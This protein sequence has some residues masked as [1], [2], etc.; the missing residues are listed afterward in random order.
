VAAEEDLSRDLLRYAPAAH[1]PGTVPTSLAHL[2]GPSARPDLQANQGGLLVVHA[3]RTGD[4]SVLAAGLLLLEAALPFDF[5]FRGTAFTNTAT[6]YWARY[7]ATGAAVDLDRAVELGTYTVSAFPADPNHALAQSNL[8]TAYWARYELASRPDDLAS[9]IH[10]LGQA[11][12]LAAQEDPNRLVT[13]SNLGVALH[14]RFEQTG[15]LADLDRAIDLGHTTT[16]A[17]TAAATTEHDA[18]RL[19]NLGIAHRTRYDRTGDTADLDSAIEYGL[20]ALGAGPAPVHLPVVLTNLGIAHHDRFTRHGDPADL[21]RAIDYQERSFAALPAD[22]HDRAPHLNNTASVYLERFDRTG[23]L[24][25]LDRAIATGD[26][27]VAAI[28]DRHPQLAWFLSTLGAALQR[29]FE[30]T[31]DLADLDRAIATK[32]HAVAISPPTAPGRALHLS[33]LGVARKLRFERTGDLADLNRAV[34]VS[35]QALAATPADHADL[36]MRHDN[37]A[38]AYAPRFDRTGVGDDLDR[39]ITH[40]EQAAAATPADHPLLARTLSNLGTDYK[41]RHDHAG[42]RADLDRAIAVGTRAVAATPADHPDLPVRLSN[43]GVAYH[44]R[45]QRVGDTADLDR[46]V[47]HLE[48]ALALTPAD[49]PGRSRYASNLVTVY[50]TRYSRTGDGTDLD[51]AVE[52][53]R[54]SVATTPEGHPGLG[55]RLGNL[56]G[57]LLAR[58]RHS[59]DHA[60]LDEAIVHEEHALAATAEDHP[61]Y[62][63]RVGALGAG[64]WSRAASTGSAQDWARAEALV[65]RSVAATA[66]DHPYRAM[67][68]RNLLLLLEER[69]DV[70]PMEARLLA[71]HVLA[72]R[73]SP[74]AQQVFAHWV[75][76]RVVHKAGEHELAGRL[77]DSAVELLPS[78]PARETSHADQE[79]RLDGYL[80]L[81]G[82]AV[83]VHCALGDPVGAVR[84]AEQG[85]G[86]LLAAQLDART[87]L[88]GLAAEHPDL[89]ARFDRVR[90]ALDVPDGGTE[91]RRRLWTEHDDLLTHIRGLPGW[92]RFL[93]PPA[94]ADLRPAAEGGSVV[95]VNAGST[96]ADAVIVTADADPV[97][98]PLPDLTL[99]DVDTHAIALAAAT[100]ATGFSAE[101]RRQRVLTDLLAWLWDTTVGPVLD[102]V[103]GGRVWWLPTGLLGQLP[104]HAAGHPGQPGAL[105]RVVSSYTPT[106]RALLRSRAQPPAEGSRLTVAMAHTPGLPDLPATVAEADNLRADTLLRDNHA[107]VADVLRALPGVSVAHF[108]CHA[109]TNPDAPSLGGLHLHDGTLPITAVSRLRL[110][111][112]EL[113]YLSA[114]STGHVSRGHANESTHLASAF[115]LAGFRHVIASLWPLNDE[116]A[117]TAAA[118]FHRHTTPPATTLHEVTR[119]LRADHPDRPHLWAPLIHSG[120]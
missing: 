13:A 41:A 71:T 9:A 60:D 116:V 77:L 33:N 57:I 69:G 110:R 114:C 100:T 2:L 95:L 50:R 97:L 63:L 47:T 76:G 105:D 17:A 99:T 81:V 104:L 59:G 45:H 38:G 91:A 53:G 120:P 39:A 46:A 16:T 11:L 65:R 18:A 40:R 101:L 54:Q 78:V 80:G 10:F 7:S 83:A 48:R 93:L 20:L 52:V 37:L 112:A 29:R 87:D 72:A 73:R 106:L 1:V 4:Q 108:A 28:P 98:V 34:D 89:A 79:H 113:A 74:P 82:E 15:D 26:G 3:L 62:A 55:I 111:G 94:W 8:G 56:G 92:D 118:R 42:D 115:Q 5:P 43:V 88:S 27:A 58:F 61:A 85:R 44:A 21:D 32:E 68:L 51:R 70:P 31:G 117:A 30:R 36:A 67:R 49:H 90:T 19:S 75:A 6:A 107:T 24:S 103:E 25:D 109:A 22:H 96:R 66:G 86:I 23:S 119:S 102:H 84:V 12:A 35:E 14:T 64:V